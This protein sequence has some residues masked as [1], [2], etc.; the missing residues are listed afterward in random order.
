MHPIEKFLR[1]K[2]RRLLAWQLRTILFQ[3]GSVLCLYLTCY[4]VAVLLIKSLSLTLLGLFGLP[5]VILAVM[6]GRMF[7]AWWRLRTPRLVARYLEDKLPE[8]QLT[9]QTCMDFLEGRADAGDVRF[10]Q[11]YLEQIAGRVEHVKIPMRTKQPWGLFAGMG[12]AINVAIWL[13]FSGPLLKKFYNPDIQFGQTHLNLEEGSITIFEPEYT[14]IPGRT[15]PLKPGTFNAFPGSL[16]RFMLKVPPPAKELYLSNSLQEEP[17]PLRL[18]QDG[19][20]SHEFVLLESQ[21]LTFLIG[22]NKNGTRTQPYEFRVK[23]DDPPEVQ[24]RSH[25][26][27]GLIS[28]MDPLVLEAELKDDFGVQILEAVVAWEGGEKRI[29]LSVPSDRKKHFLSRNQWYL[30]DLDIG[31]VDSFSIYLEAKD[32]NPIN[33]P[34]IGQSEVLRYEFESP[35]KKYDEFMKLARELLDTM[36][37]TLGDNLETEYSDGID[38]PKLREAEMKGKEIRRGLFQSLELTNALIGKVRETQNVTQLDQNF[39]L[40][41]R[42]GVSMQ[43][44][45]R[46]EMGFLYNNIFA[47]TN[48]ENRYSLLLADHG[49]EEV[50]LEKLTYDLLLQLK[51][52]AI[53]ELERDQKQMENSLDQLQELL[54]NAENMESQE[55]M[56]MFEKLMAEVMKDFEKMMQKAA[57]QMDMSMQE[58]MNQ[59][60]MNFDQQDMQSMMEQIMEALKKGDTEL[61]KKLM[62][63]M[64]SQMESATQSMQNAMGEMSPEMMA[65]MKQMREFTGLLRELKEQEEN[66]ARE[67]QDLKSKTDQEMG[68]NGAEMNQAE[69]KKLEDLMKRIVERLTNLSNNLAEFKTEDLSEQVL[70]QIQQKREATEKENLDP[71]TRLA[72]EA[73]LNNL[74][75]LLNFLNQDGLQYLKNSA[76]DSLEQANAMAEYL[77]QAEFDLGLETGLGLEK[78]LGVGE[79][80]SD[81]PLSDEISKKAR[82]KESFLESRMDLYEILDALQ[83]MRQQMENRR[84]SHM[85]QNGEDGQKRLAEKQAEIE[86]MIKEFK[87]N[88][89]ELMA[90]SPLMQKLEDIQMSMRNA[91]RKLGDARLDGGLQFEQQ[92]IQ[93]IGELMEQMQQAQQPS[94]GGSPRQMVMR[95]GQGNPNWNGD[96]VGEVFVPESQ[97]VVSKDAVKEAIRKQLQK[98]L[99]ESYSKEIRKYYEKLMD[100]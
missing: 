57:E 97:K 53:L 47:S 20:A 80:M 66:L 100:Q 61:A 30:S 89:G 37:N 73:E 34:G 92:A 98:N 83:N 3:E 91:E 79:R 88:A 86:K 46:T 75:R 38:I 70:E 7:V 52:W 35:E 26:P 56:D 31:E 27:E 16:V 22:A 84:R 25:T 59:D 94:P 43:A 28:V 77:E 85:T 24:L 13:A 64:R 11:A 49:E 17:V 33:G 40:Q 5:L 69:Q 74:E 14:Q 10:G 19:L 41:F 29:P 81:R 2:G 58:F 42:D 8:F 23:S 71:G 15:I 63:Q 95:P 65:M 93:Q 78:Q 39:L 50:Q 45:S 90:G 82:P 32:N 68:G 9:F 67:T 55:L 12:I 4:A 76:S 60:A 62:E 48:V 51:M 72:H 96:P 99:P 54:D 18:N 6:L 1:E 44:R 87:E 36:A 21:A